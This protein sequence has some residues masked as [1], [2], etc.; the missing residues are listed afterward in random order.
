MATSHPTWSSDMTLIDLSHV[1][2]QG[3][4]AYPGLPGPEIGEHLSFAASS[5]QYAAGTEFTIGTITMVSN[6]GTYLDTPGHRHRGR[7]DLAGLP[8]ER[9]VDLPAAV[10]D[11]TGGAAIGPEYLPDADLVGAAVLLRTGWDRHWRTARYGH[12][13]HPYLTADGAQHLVERG[14]V[15]VGIDAVNIDD[16]AGGERPAHTIL[17][18]ADVLIVEHL[19]G[20]DRL[21][22]GGARFTAVP[23]A[24]AGM[25]TFPVRAYA[26]VP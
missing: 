26:V 9:C 21:P 2:E 5:A 10:V 1:I 22:A 25:S 12:T 17:L 15:L 14:A 8:L 6:T 19:T 23:P 20:L 18:R 3:M 11:A 16:T 7:H 24:V 13:D 4:I